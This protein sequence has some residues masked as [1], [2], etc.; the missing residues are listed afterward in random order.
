M[1]DEEWIAAMSQPVTPRAELLLSATLYLM[2]EYAAGSPS[3]DQLRAVAH[4]LRCIACHPEIDTLIRE[5][6]G[7]LA[8][9]WERRLLGMDAFAGLGRRVH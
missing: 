8:S 5:T 6:S 9:G 4:H 2:A 1:S 7:R 3:P